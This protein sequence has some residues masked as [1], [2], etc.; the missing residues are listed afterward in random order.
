MTN[1]LC[2]KTNIIVFLYYADGSE[3]AKT[4]RPATRVK[5]H[6]VGFWAGVR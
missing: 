4:V 5:K 1:K 6:V 2:I 3:D